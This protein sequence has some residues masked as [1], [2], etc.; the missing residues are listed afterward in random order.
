M[1]QSEKVVPT[2]SDVIFECLKAKKES[3]DE[4]NSV[5]A[6]ATPIVLRKSA[7]R[8]L[9]KD[10]DNDN[11][12]DHAPDDKNINNNNKKCCSNDNKNKYELF[13][14]NDNRYDNYI[15]EQK[16]I[17]NCISFTKQNKDDAKSFL[18]T[19]ATSNFNFPATLSPRSLPHS[20]HSSTSSH[21]R[22]SSYSHS[23]F[24]SNSLESFL[25]CSK[26]GQETDVRYFNFFIVPYLFRAYSYSLTFTCL[27]STFFL[28][29]FRSHF[30]FIF[31]YI[32]NCAGHSS[33]QSRSL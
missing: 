14:D 24:H 18:P 8:D 27:S 20:P 22:Y 6:F 10:C 17:G 13:G 16:S 15:P 29:F 5:P 3:V 7:I 25:V 30:V 1:L 9:I 11:N 2:Y 26:C 33:A 21:P 23:S 32:Y 4:R 28:V 19:S 31:S 12:N